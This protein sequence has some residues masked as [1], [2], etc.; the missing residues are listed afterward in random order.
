LKNIFSEKKLDYSLTVAKNATVQKVGKRIVEREIEFFN[1]D[2]IIS[3]GYRVNSIQGTEFRIW[4]TK[5]L[6]EYQ[7]CYLVLN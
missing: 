5:R 4:A 3:V 1:L 6:R 2:V 7:L